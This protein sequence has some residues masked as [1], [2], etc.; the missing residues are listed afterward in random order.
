MARKVSEATILRGQLSK[1]FRVNKSSPDVYSGFQGAIAP[2]LGGAVGYG[3]HNVLPMIAGMM[4]T[5]PLAFGLAAGTLGT[6]KNAVNPMIRKAI[7]RSLLQS[8]GQNE[9]INPL[10]DR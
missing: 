4:G 10:G 3:T 8:L 9:D 2:L 1:P 6:V 5:S 7:Q